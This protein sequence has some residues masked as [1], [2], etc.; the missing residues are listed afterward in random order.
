M[1]DLFLSVCESVQSR[2]GSKE[3]LP[4]DLVQQLV[5]AA[6]GYGSLN[7]FNAN[8]AND[9]DI[10]AAPAADLPYFT[11]RPSS[12]F[13][14]F[15]IDEERLDK[16]CYELQMGYVLSPSVL[17]MCLTDSLHAV[18]TIGSSCE[19]CEDEAELTQRLAML[20]N[21]ALLDDAALVARYREITI[22]PL[23]RVIN[24]NL[25]KDTRPSFSLTFE[26]HWCE[27]SA[28]TWI[29]TLAGD[30]V[31]DECTITMHQPKPRIFLLEKMTFPTFKAALPGNVLA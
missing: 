17:S 28:I 26:V 15:C 1:S 24:G 4:L 7:A 13:R 14:H 19:I 30:F 31:Q 11:L 16:R 21:T 12:K 25:L 23:N 3:L 2:Y 27:K 10:L 22:S 29:G 5:A 18:E 6:L 8:G 9:L 20:A